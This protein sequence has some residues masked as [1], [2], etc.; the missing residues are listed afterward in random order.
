MTLLYVNSAKNKDWNNP[1][2][3]SSCKISDSCIH[4][5]NMYLVVHSC[6]TFLQGQY[7]DDLFQSILSHLFN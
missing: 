5:A 1:F 3:H 4:Y 2:F 7:T 6:Q